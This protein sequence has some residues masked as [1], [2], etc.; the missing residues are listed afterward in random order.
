MSAP[1]LTPRPTCGHVV[2]SQSYVDTGDPRCVYRGSPHLDS[3]IVGDALAIRAARPHVTLS[4]ALTYADPSTIQGRA[5]R[6]GAGGF[7]GFG[8]ARDDLAIGLAWYFTL[9]ADDSRNCVRGVQLG[10]CAR[11]ETE[12]LA[13]RRCYGDIV[14]N[15]QALLTGFK[16]YARRAKRAR[17]TCPAWPGTRNMVRHGSEENTIRVWLASEGIAEA[18]DALAPRD[19]GPAF[20][21]MKASI[22]PEVQP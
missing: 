21:H 19:R 10:V 3:T 22:T 11:L 18:C 4:E 8:Y 12:D 13:V 2:C 9:W 20:E 16:R 1:F 7:F 17:R 14:R 5:L 6:M 15:R